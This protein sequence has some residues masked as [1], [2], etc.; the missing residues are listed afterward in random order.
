MIY[1]EILLYHFKDFKENYEKNKAAKKNLIE[2]IINNDNSKI[3]IYLFHFSLTE[4]LMMIMTQT[5]DCIFPYIIKQY[6]H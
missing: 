3:V 6:S 1:E 2:H 4:N 5:F